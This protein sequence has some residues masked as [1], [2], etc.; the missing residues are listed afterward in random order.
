[1]KTGG[2]DGCGRVKK[3]PFRPAGLDPDVGTVSLHVL[4]CR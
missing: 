3:A 2:L 4:I 1:M